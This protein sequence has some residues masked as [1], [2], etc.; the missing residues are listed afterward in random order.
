MK[1]DVPAA[2]RAAMAVALDGGTLRAVIEGIA[3]QV[4][5]GRYPIKRALGEHVRV[6]ADVFTDGH[7]S[8]AA[9]LLFRRAD[10]A[11]WHAVFMEPQGNDR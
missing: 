8:V 6:E 3:P 10:E 11:G 7:D 5:C 9:Q 1:T 4:D 2:Q